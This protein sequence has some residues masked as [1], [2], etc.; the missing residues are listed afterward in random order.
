[1]KKQK[2]LFI[3]AIF[4]VLLSP[5]HLAAAPYYE[6]KVLRIVV[7]FSPG[8]GY[9][10]MA[11]LIA[12]YLPKYIPGKPTIIIENIPGATSMIATNQCYNIYKPDGLR[13]LSFERGLPIAQ[14]LKSEGV[15]FDLRKFSWIG[16]IS[17]EATALYLRTDLPYK[18]FRDLLNAKAPIMVGTTGPADTSGHFPILLKEFL[19]VNIKL[20]TYIATADIMLAIERKELDGRAGSYSSQKRFIDRGL[21]RA[22]IRGRVSEPAIDN[23]PVDEDLAPN[24]TVRALMAIRSAPDRIGRPFV[25]PPGT[26][27]QVM[28]ILRDAFAKVAKDPAVKEEAQKIMMTV[29][30]TSADECLNVLNYVFSQPEDIVKEYGKY[31]KY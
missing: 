28:K 19:G 26:P 24:A 21:T 1:M 7:G 4:F 22:F 13:I 15:R 12:K 23:L 30:H 29:E 2:W 31:V 18:T 16:S 6:G 25:A 3:G 17:S 27:N 11:R 10:N 20:I 9:D 8:G 5:V 14:L